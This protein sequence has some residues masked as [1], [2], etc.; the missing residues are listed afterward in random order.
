MAIHQSLLFL[1]LFY[2]I[3]KSACSSP[4]SS[5]QTLQ[6]VRQLIGLCA[7][8]KLAVQLRENLIMK[9]SVSDFGVFGEK[10]TWPPG[11]VALR[12]MPGKPLGVNLSDSAKELGEQLCDTLT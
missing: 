9:I 5:L 7:S 3:K 11:F 1:R 4:G 8:S 12:R 6:E 10:I 2:G